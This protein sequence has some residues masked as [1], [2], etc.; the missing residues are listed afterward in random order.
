MELGKVKYLFVG[1]AKTYGDNS[2]LEK[3]DQEWTTAIYRGKTDEAVYLTETGFQND[4]VGDKRN[5]GGPE[6]AVFCYNIDHYEEWTNEL[7]QDM[8]AGAFGENLAVV[9]LDESNVCI[10]DVYQ[11]G[12]AQIQVSQPR[13]P[14]WRPARKHRIIDLALKIEDSGRTGWYFRVIEEGRVQAD[15][16]FSLLE[17]P[18][19]EWTI[20]ACNEVMYKQKENYGLT[21]SLRDVKLLAENWQRSLQKRL[22]GIPENIEPRV[23]G[24]NK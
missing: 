13:R 21:A 4:E 11:L 3:M 12:E 18:H 17:R 6:K 10:G 9:G 22:D 20:D 7:G 5:H 8:Q 16:K 15:D 19:P 24:P 2:A 23:F 14:C 1:K